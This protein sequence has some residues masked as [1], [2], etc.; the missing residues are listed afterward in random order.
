[1]MKLHCLLPLSASY[2]LLVLSISFNFPAVQ[3][4]F[5]SSAT[6]LLDAKNLPSK[7]KT[8]R[9]VGHQSATVRRMSS[10]T[11]WSEQAGET[12][13]RQVQAMASKVAEDAEIKDVDVWDQV[14]KNIPKNTAGTGGDVFSKRTKQARD[15]SSLLHPNLQLSSRNKREEQVWSALRNLELDMQMLDDQAGQQA[16]LTKLELIMLS[17]SVTAAA[18]GPFILGGELTEFLAPT[19]AA[20][21]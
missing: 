15:R 2:F 8:D 19:S 12:A 21:K 4:F 9:N 14:D 13:L 10:L 7:I 16:Q 3:C 1:M 18:S 17:L 6:P 20:C 5:A 11:K